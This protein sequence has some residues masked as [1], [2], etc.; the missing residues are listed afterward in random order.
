MSESQVNTSGAGVYKLDVDIAVRFLQGV[1]L[2]T[3]PDARCFSIVVIG[4]S[5][6]YKHFCLDDLKD[7]DTILQKVKEYVSKL[8]PSDHV[9]FQ[10]LP[11][12]VKPAKG[13]GSEKD[14]R[15]GRWLWVDYDYKET[16]DRAGFEGCKELED[17]TLECY[18]QEGGKWIH[19]RRPPLNQVLNDVKNKLG[20]EPW[21]V[22]DSGAGYHLYFRL[23]R[24]IDATTL[25]KLEAWLVDKLGGDPQA[26][27]L[28]RILRLPGSINPRTQRLVQVIYTGSQEIDP[29]ELLKRIESESKVHR[30]KPEVHRETGLREFSD[31]EI[32]RIVDLLKDAYKPGYR[33]YLL[34]YL[35]GWLAKARVSPVTAVKIAKSLYE[36]TNDNDPLK[37][38]LSAIVY[39]YKKMG[40]N[41]DEYASEIENI[42]GVKPYGLEREIQEDIIK[43]V[44]GLQELLEAV[45]GEDK[46]LAII[47]ELSEILGTLSPYRDSIIELIDYEKQLYAVANLRKLVIVRAKKKDNTLIYKERVAVISPTKVTVYSNPIGGI[48][49]YEVVF[50]GQTLRKPLVIGPATIDEI[51]D[52]I[53]AEGLVYHRKLV[54]DVLSAIIQ[55]F[56]RKNKAEI[57]TEIES[58]GFYWVDGKVVSVKYSVDNID[59]EK[60]KQA[61]QLLNELADTWFKHVQDKFST[62]IKWGAIA[63]FGYV[64]KQK[65]KWIPWLYLYGDSATGK[66]TLGKII[67]R[68]WSLDNKYDKTGASIDTVPRLGYVLSMSTFPVLINEPGNALSKEDVVETIKNAVDN[69]V[70]RGK[71]VKGTYTEIPALSCLVFTSNKFLPR[72]DTLLRR[73]KIITFSYGEKIPPDKQKEFKE[74]VEPR[75]GI[76]SEIGKCV[77]K[78]VIENPDI[79]EKMDGGV[80]L[81]KCYEVAGL[82]KSAWLNLEHIEAPDPQETITEEFV[83]RLKRYVNDSFARYVSRVI[84]IDRDSGRTHPLSPDSFSIVEKFRVLL[85]KNLLT[86]IRIFRNDKVVITSS[87]LRELGLEDKVNLKSLAEMFGWEYKNIKL[88]GKVLKGVE[89][90]IKKLIYLLTS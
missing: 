17:H 10:V 20:L 38:R 78:Q 62:I 5:V 47:H 46:A 56:V 48:T 45:L 27:D 39:S 88:Y 18:Y 4:G 53:V 57:K 6:K 8:G 32:L 44:S 60:L 16:V 64:L 22:V 29:D 82:E 55:A 72:D 37:T 52:R 33:Q 58:P 86:G 63:P 49:K 54:Y 76:L 41:I 87:L 23:S 36:S 71:Y 19:V 14:V 13:R 70:A 1:W 3:S 34:L 7:Y 73:F 66:S 68:L 83:E 75:L 50:E 12:F 81:E 15:I 65:G 89:I 61:L 67:L 24:E 42:A 85:E 35:A 25:K 59:V 43:G 2:Y 21:F 28:A 77:A 69:L 31:S 30:E 80:L 11:L 26:K 90:D 74:K 51:C 84:E 40:I 79:L 9:Y